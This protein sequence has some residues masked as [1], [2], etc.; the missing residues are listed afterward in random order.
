M[1]IEKGCLL[2][3]VVIFSVFIYTLMSV[4]G[5]LRERCDA[6]DGVYIEYRCFKGEF[7][8]VG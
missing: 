7:V 5:E 1:S 6:L 8:E 4:T 3:F 2:A